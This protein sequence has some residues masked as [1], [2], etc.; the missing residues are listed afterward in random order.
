MASDSSRPDHSSHGASIPPQHPDYQRPPCGAPTDDEIDLREL[1]DVVWRGKWVIV[2]VTSVFAFAAVAYAL[3]LPNIYQSEALL[4]PSD[5]AQGGGVSRM[6]GQF[7]GLASLAGIN[8]GSGAGDDKVAVAIA[9]MRSRKFITGFIEKYE[10]LPELMAVERWNRGSGELVFDPELY[11]AEEGKWVRDVAPPKEAKPSYWE[12]YKAFSQ[13]LSIS[14][15]K[16]TG[17]VTVAVEHQSPYVAKRWVRLLVNTVNEVMKEKDVAEAQRS[18]EFLQSQ[19]AAVAL[20]DMRT[21]FY[22][23]IE[24]Q[25]KT[26][27]LAEVRDEYVFSTIDPPV[28]A[29]EK[30]TPRRVQ[31]GLMGALIGLIMSLTFLFVRQLVSPKHESSRSS[32]IKS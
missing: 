1:W 9:V 4:A 20:A 28:A 23:L 7:G 3:S 2:A 19:L 12:A 18:I 25:T 16:E 13:I 8:L 21:V 31:V 6:A 32:S 26:I 29:E 30:I 22:Q 14:Q 10:L 24:E 5:D 11:N 17:F 15:E 27:M